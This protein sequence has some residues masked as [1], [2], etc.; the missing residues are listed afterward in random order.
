MCGI[1]N[2]RVL[3]GPLPLVICQ[4]HFKMTQALITFA[5]MIIIMVTLAR[6][7]LICVWGCMKPIKDDF[8]T[9]VAISQ[10][11]LMCA[12]HT[13][14]WPTNNLDVSHHRP[15]QQYYLVRKEQVLY[16]IGVIISAQTYRHF[17]NITLLLDRGLW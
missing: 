8:L 12:L 13:W 7:V 14:C 2:L 10:A 4:A 3:Y 1:R 11:T 5:I 15:L 17:M 16:N 9:R 6:F